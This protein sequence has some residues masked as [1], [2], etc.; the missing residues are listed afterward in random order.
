LLEDFD[1]SVN[2]PKEIDDPT[3]SK[4]DDWIDEEVIPDPEIKK[5][6][7]W[8]EDAPREI[9]DMDDKKP[10]GWKDDAP[11]AIIDST[12]KKPED[13]NDEEDGEWEAPIIPNPIC[14]EFGCGEWSPRTKLNPEYKGKWKP[15]M[16]PNPAY[17]GEWKARQIPNPD[18]FEDNHPHNFKKMSAIAFE[19]WTMNNMISFDNILITHDKQS[20]DDFA[21]KTWKIKFNEQKRII[22]ER[23]EVEEREKNSIMNQIYNFMTELVVFASARPYTVFG[24]GLIVILLPLSLCVCMSPGTTTTKPVKKEEGKSDTKEESVVPKGNSKVTERKKQTKSR[25]DE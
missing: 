19:I 14:E 24:V 10:E 4:P 15:S 5:P 6:E 21:N 1:P 9:P 22:E 12:A 3:D 18:Y 20:A 17:L 2:P 25:L 23:K 16:I 8:N 7:D 13:W 11:E